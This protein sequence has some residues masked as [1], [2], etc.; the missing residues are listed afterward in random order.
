LVNAIN[1][2]AGQKTAEKSLHPHH[3]AANGRQTVI[4]LFAKSLMNHDGAHGLLSG[5]CS[6]PGIQQHKGPFLPS[7]N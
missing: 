7:L 2:A 6:Q 4:G 5:L 1:V 3:F